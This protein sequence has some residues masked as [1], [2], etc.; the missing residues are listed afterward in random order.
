MRGV[1]VIASDAAGMTLELRTDSFE[2]VV[3]DVGGVSYRRLRVPEYVHGYTEVVGK[4][5]LPVKGILLDLP[6]GY[7]GTLSIESVESR[8]LSNYWIYPVPEKGVSG[9]G[10]VATVSEVFAIDDAAYRMN[11]FYPDVVAWAG[12]TYDYR[13]QKKLQ[14]FFNPLSFNPVTKEL[15]QYTRIRVRGAYVALA[16]E[17]PVVR[18]GIPLTPAPSG[19]ARAMVW[20]PPAPASA[21]KVVVSEEGIYRL[22]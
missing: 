13:G 10:E 2:S 12:E 15:I 21:Y 22:T 1:E 11:S 20:V 16:E 17:I 7:D 4:P 14:V 9:E 18:S 8:E 3:L 19:L 5:E 6:A